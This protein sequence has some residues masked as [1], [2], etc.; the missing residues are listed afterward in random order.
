MRNYQF[1]LRGF[2]I[3]IVLGVGSVGYIVA[4]EISRP[5]LVV[6]FLDVGQG[7][8]ILMQTPARHTILIDGGPD[9]TVLTR[10]GET[11]PW[12]NRTIDLLVL[13]HPDADH[14]TGLVEVLRRY[15]V[16]TVLLTAVVDPSPHY[17]TW[18]EAVAAERATV[19]VAGKVTSIPLG[20]DIGLQ[21]MHPL[22]SIVGQTFAVPNDSSVVLRLDYRERSFLFTGDI[23]R[24]GEDEMIA[25]GESLNIDVLQAPHHGSNTSASQELLDHTT[26]RVVVIS[27]GRDNR[28][29]HP[30]QKVLDR[31]TQN[32][33]PWLVTAK[34]GT[35]SLA[36]D[37]KRL[38]QLSP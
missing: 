18:L 3:A 24:K 9:N 34:E 19:L 11:M 25:A 27:A 2:F 5:P 4:A 1:Y 23:Q 26:P 33:L 36:S 29:N 12:W 30:A 28:Y 8:G 17:Q 38:W 22:Q 14:V 20:S 21:I 15:Q 37:G 31:L 32:H 16:K 6:H 10:L 35:I 13:T 7:D